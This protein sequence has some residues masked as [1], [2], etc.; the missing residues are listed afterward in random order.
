MI[1][2]CVEYEHHLQGPLH[3]TSWLLRTY[4][5]K[6]RK[7]LKANWMT[8]PAISFHPWVVGD[9][10]TTENLITAILETEEKTFHA[11][12]IVNYFFSV[13]YHSKCIIFIKNIVCSISKF[14]YEE[15]QL[16]SETF[17][18]STMYHSTCIRV[19]IHRRSKWIEL[20]SVFIFI[21]YLLVEWFHS[22]A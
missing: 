6:Q 5:V 7:H 10:L 9:W 20:F 8:L 12:N 14:Y 17:K 11:I 16:Y 15:N 4:R 21:L 19:K 13:I 22:N 3:V 1:T 2:L 18:Y